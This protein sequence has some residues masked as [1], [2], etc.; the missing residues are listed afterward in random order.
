M[1]DAALVGAG[2]SVGAA[3]PGARARR[4]D[5]LDAA[6]GIGIVLVVIGHELRA[7]MAAG[8]AP[9]GWQ[10]PVW[11]AAIYA[12]HMPLFFV[13]SGMTFVGS[14]LTR[15]WPVL[16]RSRLQTLVYPYILWSVV[17][18][19]LSYMATGNVNHPMTPAAIADIWRQ[20]VLQYWFLYALFLIQLAFLPL[21]RVP[22]AAA[23]LSLVL[24]LVAWPPMAPIL[25]EVV[26][27]F[28]FFVVGA[29]TGPRLLA[30]G[31]RI[32]PA[33]LAMLAL[34]AALLFALL[35]VHAFEH[36]A[37]RLERDALALCGVVV[38]IAVAM[39]AGHRSQLL[40]LLG[41]ASM[42]IYVLHTL[43]GWLPRMLLHHLGLFSAGADMVLG[44][45]TGI[46]VPVAID[47]IAA[48]YGATL[49]LGLGRATSAGPRRI[50]P[51]GS[52]ATPG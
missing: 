14:A 13:L 31:F 36:E 29:V 2:R 26:L 45:V 39:L 19:L 18:V 8:V 24:V 20:P 42:A 9:P 43:V 30:R 40:I 28:P 44:T 35:F 11:D 46:A 27:M 49:W 22:L 7:Q 4:L 16:L 41:R 12:F 51:A 25:T 6:R 33:S 10:A 5:W 47:R 21:A 48:R 34:G 32:A 1:P 17:S 52:A 23:L 15:P 50:T 3:S 38:V 37:S